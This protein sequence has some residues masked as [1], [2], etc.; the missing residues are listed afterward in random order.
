MLRRAILCLA[1]FL[2]PLASS[3]ADLKSE[4][5]LEIP[6]ASVTMEGNTATELPS[7][8]ISHFIIHIRQRN[9]VTP[10]SKINTESANIVMTQIATPE[11]IVCNFDLSHYAGFKLRRGRNSIEMLFTDNFSRQHYAS[12][13]IQ[14]PDKGAKA[15][16]TR[17]ASGPPE[18]ITGDKYAVVIGISKY[19]YAG[20]GL[21]NLKFAD[22]DA[23]AFRDFLMSPDGGSFPKDNILFLVNEDATVENVRTGLFG[24]LSKP[25]PQDLVVIYIAGHGAP[26]PNNPAF[27]YFLTHDT[28]PDSMSGTALRMTELQ[29]AFRGIRSKR[30]VTFTDSCHSYG[31]SGARYGASQPGNN[32]VN[33]Y[34]QQYAKGDERAV[35]TASDVSQLSY[36]SEKWGGGHGVFTHFLLRGLAGAADANQD[37]SVTAGELFAYIHDHVAAETQ[38]QQTPVALPGLADN[39]PLSGIGM[40]RSAQMRPTSPTPP[41][42]PASVLGL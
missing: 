32:L 6:E 23:T 5:W 40:R 7:P 37:G 9:Q 31:V 10:F 33:Q 30:V 20:A 35:M 3:P 14:V 11:G 4:I 2:V 19:K 18:K 38:N 29:E 25:R 39:L 28:K 13:L 27:I 15:P 34:L 8:D 24:F 36:E 16:A 12:F 41:S 1:V 42:K 21:T 26:D 22:R 17:K